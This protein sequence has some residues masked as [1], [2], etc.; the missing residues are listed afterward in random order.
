MVNFK[1]I[2]EL[3]SK[4][5][6]YTDNEEHLVSIISN[7]KIITNIMVELLNYEDVIL[8]SCDIDFDEEYNREYTISLFDNVDTEDWHINVEKCCN[9]EKNIYY[10]TDGYVLFHEDVNSKDLVDM[11]RNEFMPLGEHDWFTVGDG[12]DVDEDELEDADSDESELSEKDTYN[13]ESTYIS[14]NG[15]GTPVG[16]TKNW[17]ATENGITCHSS[18]SH[19]SDD[20]D[21]LRKIASEFG[22]EL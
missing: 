9:E 17:F 22:I 7:K 12:E 8:D 19:F 15:D 4:L 13:S 20:I 10:S 14:K 11:Q 6:D 16:F 5:F 21:M 1:N 2:E 18:Y 3:A